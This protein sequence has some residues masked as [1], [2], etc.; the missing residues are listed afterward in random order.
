M[1]QT[2]S[3]SW[4]AIRT[5]ARKELRAAFASPVALLF[6]GGFLVVTLFTFFTGAR[7]FAR[8]LADV[9]PLFEWLPV[10]LLFLVSALTMRSWADERKMGTLEVLATLPIRSRDL[11]LGKFVAVVQLVGLAL[12]LTLP[13]PWMVASLGALDPGPVVGGYVGALLLGAAYGAIGLAVSARTDNQVVALISTLG[14]AGAFVL[15]GSEVATNLV[16]HEAGELLAALGLGARFESIERGVFD[17]RDAVYYG[18]IATVALALNVL[19]L[20]QERLDRQSPAGRAAVR[21]LRTTTALIA[22]NAVLAN[23]WL[24]P[25]QSARVDLTASGEYS[26]DAVTV[27]TLQALDEP[28]TIEAYFSERTHPLLSPLVSQIRDV[29]EEVRIKGA[30]NVRVTFA[31][32]NADDAIAARIQEDYGISSVPFQVSDRTQQAVVNSYF[33][34]VVRYG[35]EFE[36]LGFQDLIEV[37]LDAD[38]PRVRLRNLEYDL[39][40]AVRRVSREFQSIDA[41]IAALP[42]DATITLYASPDTFPEGFDELAT[43]VRE[44]GSDLSS[45]GTSLRFTEVDPSADAA[46]QQRLQQELAIRPLAVDLFATETFYFDIV[47]RAGDRVV[48]VVPRGEESEGDVRRSMEATLRRVTPGQLTTVGLLTEP[49]EALPANPNLPPQFQPPPRAPEYRLLERLLASNYEVERVSVED[50]RV[51]GHI[52]TLIVGKPGELTPNALFAIDQFVMRGGALVALAGHAEV[53]A[54]A[55]GLRTR[56]LEDE[57]HELLAHYGVVVEAGLA[58]DT[59]SATFPVPVRERR[60]SVVLERMEL[61]PYPFFPDIRRD[62]MADHP[63]LAGL[64]SVTM[65]WA[66]ALRVDAPEGVDATPLLE[67][68]ERSWVQAGTSIDPDFERYPA[69]GFPADEVGMDRQTLAVALTGTFPSYYADRPSPLFGE[70]EFQDPEADRTGRTLTH[71]LPGARVVVLGS[72]ELASDLMLSLARQPGGEAHDGNVTLLENVV[73][74]STEDTDLLEIRSKSGAVGTLRPLSDQ[75]RR[76]WELGQLVFAAWCVAGL[77]VFPWLRRRRVVSLAQE[78]ER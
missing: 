71:S 28:L 45:R 2:M 23:V 56:S 42:S 30:P 32:P 27:A 67:S 63:V 76:F 68:S 29:L 64:A 4:S 58:L 60:G 16:G 65:P 78:V 3:P 11:V 73:D 55:Q 5:I 25:V 19:A 36:V 31:D 24:A 34:L 13:L 61:L 59:Q 41:V 20:E 12:V 53:E 46:L 6:L 66:S 75:Q 47:V 26:L 74:W 69:T 7:F 43:W 33:H 35:D 1:N 52:D 39:T 44:V 57:W 48:R 62:G 49:P 37:H 15:I 38:E 9:R 18:S 10:L 54:D 17:V 21:R 40:R 14:V 51:P 77:A 8:G 50:G 72:A 22:V 70:D